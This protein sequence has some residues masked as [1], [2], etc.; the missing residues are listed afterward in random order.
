MFQS[1]ARNRNQGRLGHRNELVRCGRRLHVEVMERR[2]LLSATPL[3]LQLTS[4]S[5]NLLSGIFF[6]PNPS[7]ANIGAGSATNDGGFIDLQP[8]L[9]AIGRSGVTTNSTGSNFDLPY[10][11]GRFVQFNDVTISVHVPHSVS[12]GLH[13]WPIESPEVGAIPIYP[14]A[15]IRREL[16]PAPTSRQLEPQLTATASTLSPKSQSVA[17]A[18]TSISGEWARAVV[19]ELAAEATHATSQVTQHGPTSHSPDV[20]NPAHSNG[21]VSADE[22]QHA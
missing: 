6:N 20:H 1:Q 13:P 7:S 19:F 21:P 8:T 4:V 14:V 9:S 2:L 3:Q 11:P 15:G 12:D 22:P 18:E 5:P 10:D 16:D 17:P